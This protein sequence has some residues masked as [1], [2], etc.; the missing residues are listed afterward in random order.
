MQIADNQ[1][2]YG[3]LRRDFDGLEVSFSSL[4][5][6]HDDLG[7]VY[8]TLSEDHTFTLERI[9]ADRGLD[10]RSSTSR[11]WGPSPVCSVADRVHALFLQA[12]PSARY[13]P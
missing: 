5:T 9:P 8:Q 12:R 7:E 4:E 10:R 11:R 3:Y 2:A 1:Q 13:R 6:E